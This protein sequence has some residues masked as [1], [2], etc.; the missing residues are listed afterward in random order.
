M[1]F[2]DIMP[3]NTHAVLRW[4][5]KLPEEWMKIKKRENDT[6]EFEINRAMIKLT[7]GYEKHRGMFKWLFEESVDELGVDKKTGWLIWFDA[8][9]RL[10]A[11]GPKIF[12]P[13]AEQ[14]DSMQHVDI[15]VPIC[16]Y[17]QPY[18]SMVIRI[19]T[20]SRKRLAEELN[21]PFTCFPL[22]IIVRTRTTVEG[23][24]VIFAAIQ[25]HDMNESDVTYVMDDR[26]EH[27]SIEEALKAIFLIDD[28]GNKERNMYAQRA[29]RAAVNLMLMLVHYG[30]RDGGP[31]VPK[32]WEKH[33]SPKCKHE[34]LKHADFR[35]VEMVQHVVVRRIERIGHGEEPIPSGIEMPPHWRSGHWRN[36]HH[37]PGNQRTKL[38]FINPV[39]VRSDRAVGDL[40]DSLAV[41][42]GV[43]S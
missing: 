2:S 18:P 28:E 11:N 14:F 27:P 1:N 38:I 42:E 41:Y 30:H 25:F 34:H 36:Q 17:H 5:G 32:E 12:I 7:P 16:S 10:L 6:C 3:S 13:T 24:V 15:N 33:R 19:P 37:G 8:A 23:Y 29:S 35:T 4:L 43:R 21:A 26:K 39:L 9:S 40:A 22:W 31:L 20:E